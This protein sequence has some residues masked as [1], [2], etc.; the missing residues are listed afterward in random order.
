VLP[1]V[2]ASGILTYCCCR[3]T[4]SD[5]LWCSGTS[6]LIQLELA[7]PDKAATIG[8]IPKPSIAVCDRV[9]T[10]AFVQMTSTEGGKEMLAGIKAEGQ[11]SGIFGPN[12]RISTGA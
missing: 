4:S 6:Y 8:D 9:P 10:R 11:N 7:R 2:F 5:F 3:T 12:S 1:S